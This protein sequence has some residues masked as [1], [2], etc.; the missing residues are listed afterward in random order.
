MNVELRLGLLGFAAEF[1]FLEERH[2]QRA[3]CVAGAVRVSQGGADIAVVAVELERGEAICGGGFALLFGGLGL[4][5]HGGQVF[6]IG[7]GLV[8]GGVDVQLIEGGI[9]RIVSKRITLRQGQ[10]DGA[11]QGQLIFLQSVLRNDQLLL[12]GL[13][14][15]AG[16]Q[17]I[18][19]RSCAGLVVCAA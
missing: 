10:S 17:L 9:G 15:D 18:E 7:V 8:N 2:T 11:R 14:V 4:L 19:Q 6:A 12:E 13:V 3:G 16:A 5:E 1:K